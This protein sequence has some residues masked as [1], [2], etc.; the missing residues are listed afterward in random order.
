[1][2]EAQWFRNQSDGII[3]AI[4]LD[5]QTGRPEAVPVKPG[6]T[7]ELTDDEQRRTAGAPSSE[8]R[9]PLVHGGPNGGP[10]LLAVGEGHQRPLRPAPVEEAA[11]DEQAGAAPEGSR[12]AREEVGVP[13][14]A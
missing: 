3:G 10:A 8:Q 4:K 1:M 5:A 7:I 11:G 12:D 9:N 14:A 13:P 6:A 2:G